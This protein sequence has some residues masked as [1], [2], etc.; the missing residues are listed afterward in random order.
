MHSALANLSVPELSLRLRQQELVADFSRFAL[1]ADDL[2]SILDKASEVAAEGLDAR[3][4][5]VLEY[6]SGDAAFLVRAGVGWNDGVVG[7]AH[8]GADLESPAGY[9]FRSGQPVISNHLANEHRFRTPQLLADHGIRSAINVLIQAPGCEPF[10]VLEGDSTYRGEFNDHDTAFLQ[11]LANTLAAAVEGQKRR[12]AQDELLVQMDALLQENRVLL[13][14]KDLLIREVH[15]RIKNSLQLVQSI[16]FLQARGLANP[17]SK[18]PLEEAATRIMTI[19]AVHRRL[20]DGGSI[21]ATDAAQYLHSLLNDIKGLLPPSASQ[22]AL[23]LDVKAF[24][25]AV[26]DITPLGLITTE[27]VTN[28][29]KHGKGAIRV[30]VRRDAEEVEIAVSDEG[31]GFPAG[32]NPAASRGLGMRIVATLAKRSDGEAVAVDRSVPFGRIVVKMAVAP[33]DQTAPD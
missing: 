27:L 2:Q 7:H 33:K 24:S 23:E 16:L 17:E 5:K 13:S 6:R 20:Y 21:A 18:L 1:Q 31:P 32:F 28:A 11:A 26:D 14:E 4:A 8:V 29:I 30:S 25:L 22:R 3:F 10:G 19:A 12:E 15:H 9:A